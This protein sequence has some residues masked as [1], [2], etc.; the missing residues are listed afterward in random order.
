MTRLPEVAGS[1]SIDFRWRPFNVRRVMVQQNNVPFKDK[2]VKVAY[3]WRDVERRAQRYGLT[4]KLPAPYPL[5][6]SCSPARSP[7]S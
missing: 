5:P 4:P 3:M 2:P 6:A 1:T 7:C